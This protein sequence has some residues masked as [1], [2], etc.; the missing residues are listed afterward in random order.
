MGGIII[1]IW[2][3]SQIIFWVLYS[4]YHNSYLGINSGSRT[5]VIT[6][7][8]FEQQQLWTF[9][10]SKPEPIST[11][12][13]DMYNNDCQY[14]Q[15]NCKAFRWQRFFSSLSWLTTIQY[16]GKDIDITQPSDITNRFHDIHS[17]DPHRRYP[18]LFAQY[19]WPS[20][21][22][23]ST[24][25]GL[26]HITRSNTIKLGE[27]GIR[28]SCD[29][30]K[31]EKISH[32]TYSEFLQALNDHNPEYRYP[33]NTDDLAHALAFNYYHYLKD[34]KKSS[35]YYMVASF[36]DHTPSIT[37]SMP[38]IIQW[39][40]GNNKISAFLW[41]DRLQNNYKELKK[42][43]LPD[44]KRKQIE[45]TVKTAIKKMSTEFSLFILTQATKLATEKKA[46]ESCIHSTSCLTNQ[47]YIATAIRQITANCT[48]D[49]LSCEILH[50][51]QDAG[52]I[53]STSIIS[54]DQT[55]HYIR[56]PEDNIW[57]LS[58]R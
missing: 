35:L 31:I 16:I 52:F 40:D 6:L 57:Q 3:I 38:A 25:T 42:T 4:P 9:T 14:G 44:D 24:N 13:L 51:G 43:D 37:V 53:I 5:T 19:I 56:K 48:T 39:K 55:M 41:Y 58:P 8:G 1:I 11:G 27:E 23:D 46:N 2:R 50:I 28:Y 33:C 54:P 22:K 36:H 47:G 10:Q 32:L 18:H 7:T 26:A 17:L 29:M 45:D 15:G 21:K 34:T 30:N 12:S 49:K 20:T